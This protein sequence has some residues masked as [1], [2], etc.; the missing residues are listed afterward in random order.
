MY[1]E[2]RLSRRK[3]CWKGRDEGWKEGKLGEM[4]WIGD[5][6]DEPGEWGR[7]RR[8]SR[9]RGQTMRRE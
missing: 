9:K 6:R 5:W 3:E 2:Q 4:V 8:Q 7:V 1:A